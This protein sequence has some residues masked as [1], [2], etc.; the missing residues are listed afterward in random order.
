MYLIRVTM[1]L[2]LYTTSSFS[3]LYSA[4]ML[5]KQYQLASTLLHSFCLIVHVIPGQILYHLRK[6]VFNT[7]D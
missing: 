2:L 3:G 4:V 1:T 7:F 5:I 6:S